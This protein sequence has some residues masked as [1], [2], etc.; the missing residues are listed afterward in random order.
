[1]GGVSFS[2]LA[3]AGRVEELKRGGLSRADALFRWDRH[4]WCPEIF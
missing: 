4:P 2:E 3:R 1:M